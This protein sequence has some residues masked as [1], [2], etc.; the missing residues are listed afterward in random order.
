[1]LASFP[2]SLVNQKSADLGIQNR[3]S[4]TTSRFSAD[5]SL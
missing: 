1:M 2:A 4:L 3:F 5:G